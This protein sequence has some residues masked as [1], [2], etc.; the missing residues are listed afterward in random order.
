[1]TMARRWV[2]LPDWANPNIDFMILILYFLFF[3]FLLGLAGCPDGDMPTETVPGSING[4]MIRSI[5]NSRHF[6]KGKPEFRR[7]FL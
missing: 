1:M 4:G 3:S 6:V 2:S 7:A 5:C